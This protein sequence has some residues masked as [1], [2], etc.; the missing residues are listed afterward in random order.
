MMNFSWDY[1]NPS[2]YPVTEALGFHQLGSCFEGAVIGSA[3]RRAGAL[4]S[5]PKT[6]EIAN[7]WCVPRKS[8][9][10]IY[11]I[12]DSHTV[13][14]R[15][16]Q[17]CAI[18]SAFSEALATSGPARRAFFLREWAALAWLFPHDPGLPQ[19]DQMLY[20]QSAIDTVS[21]AAGRRLARSE[22]HIRP[23]SYLP[24]TRC[25]IGYSA[26]SGATAVVGKLQR[27]AVHGHRAMCEL[28]R[29]EQRSFQMAEPLDFDALLSC[30]WERFVRGQRLDTILS[31][32]GI[33]DAID[34][35][36]S[37][38]AGLNRMTIA[39]LPVRDAQT[40]HERL[41][42]KV[43]RRIAIAIPALARDTEQLII[44]LGQAQP[45]H[46]QR[47][48]RTIHGDF[49]TAN[50]LFDEGTAVFID[51]DEI[52]LGD[53]A[54]DLALFATRLLLGAAVHPADR[55]RA[56]NFAVSLPRIYTEAGGDPIP[57]PVYAW[58][59]AALLVGRQVKTCIR[60]AAPGLEILSDR[61]LSWARQILSRGEVQAA[62]I[63]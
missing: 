32:G 20:G 41:S 42:K 43:A 60:H 29:N 25:T 46:S 24:G 22:L 57:A 61:L 62:D 8:L 19:L 9:F 40:A 38:L 48:P 51:L 1:G 52:A 7:V 37:A 63:S 59:V 18:A 13:T 50:I 3:L 47:V 28:W 23:F 16:F 21:S 39:D 34:C 5:E 30:R 27:S 10:V 53:P 33:A 36:M 26:N 12:D 4:L 35:A 11:Q 44:Q 6:V 54:Y 45:L 55:E 49:H 17:T 2:G 31:P 56:A 15:F 14:V 58:Y